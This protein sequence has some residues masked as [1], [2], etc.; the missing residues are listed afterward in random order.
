[1]LS[2]TAL[3]N[4]AVCPAA[5][6]T[7]GQDKKRELQAELTRVQQQIREEEARRRREAWEAAQKR[8]EREAVRAGKGAFFPKRAEQKRQQLLARYQEL[9]DS[10]RLEKVMAKRRR[11]NA[12]KDH[13][14]VPRARREA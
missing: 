12:A 3:C 2:S 11:K 9:K 4:K 1:M 14:Y 13:R 6:K 10:G 8:G 7:K 5:Q